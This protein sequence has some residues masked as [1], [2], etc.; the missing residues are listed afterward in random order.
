MSVT[1]RT[2]DF[3]G[4]VAGI[5]WFAIAGISDSRYDCDP[6][7]VSYQC[8][9]IVLMH[10]LLPVNNCMAVMRSRRF[11]ADLVASSVRIPSVTRWNQTAR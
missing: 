9:I 1:I 6:I 11:V 4:L 5:L 2:H 10:S 3:Y 8:Q 7:R